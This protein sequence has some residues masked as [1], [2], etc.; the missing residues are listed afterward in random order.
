M[1]RL[2]AERIGDRTARFAIKAYER[3]IKSYLKRKVKPEIKQA[4]Q[5]QVDNFDRKPDFRV[6]VS[7]PGRNPSLPGGYGIA[8]DAWPIGEHA[9]LWRLLS[10]GADEHKIPLRPKG[11]K[12]WLIYQKNYEPKTKIVGNQLSTGGS[13]AYS[14]PIVKKKQVTHPGFDP[15]RWTYYLMEEYRPRWRAH[16]DGILRDAMRAARAAR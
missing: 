12:S 13:G 11:P 2:A 9:D 1:P 8:L 4:L 3:E 7:G 5:K 15:R 10:R 14:G 16:V 6:R